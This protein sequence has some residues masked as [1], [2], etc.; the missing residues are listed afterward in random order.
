MGITP[1]MWAARDG[2][3]V[4]VKTL[5]AHGAAVN[6]RWDTFRFRDTPLM[7]AVVAPT[8]SLAIL[9]ALIHGGADLTARNSAGQTALAWA[10]FNHQT[11]AARFLRA[12]GV[13]MR[14]LGRDPAAAKQ[15]GGRRWARDR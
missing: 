2:D 5:L 13:K 11:E 8:S 6:A 4:A 7:L 14:K 1:L 10:L 12:A 9:Q 15:Q 3:L